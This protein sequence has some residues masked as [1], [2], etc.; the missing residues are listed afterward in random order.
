MTARPANPRLALDILQATAE[1]VEDKGPHGVTM[2]AV[3]ERVGYSPTTI[4]LYFSN[5]DQLL[6]ETEERAF[7]WLAE[8]L[9][10]AASSPSP[11]ERIRQSARAYVE[12]A[13]AHPEMY[14]LMFEHAYSAEP[15]DADTWS[16]GIQRRRRALLDARERFEAAVAAGELDASTDVDAAVLVSWAAL[17]GLVSLALSGRLMGPSRVLPPGLLEKRVAELADVALDAWVTLWAPPGAAA[18]AAG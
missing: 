11:L 10:R 5:K 3:A 6:N 8:D 7:E 2:R 18:E 16:E 4:Y 17:H 1:L 15:L 12:W 13:L 9:A 14:K